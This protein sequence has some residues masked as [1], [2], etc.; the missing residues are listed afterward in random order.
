MLR[1]FGL[2][3]LIFI[4]AACS[5]S[6]EVTFV[7]TPSFETQ[8]TEWML[9][10]EEQISDPVM[11]EKHYSEPEVLEQAL[12]EV[13]L[14]H[15]L[16]DN[17]GN[18]T[19]EFPS[20]RA[21]DAGIKVTQSYGYVPNIAYELP[22]GTM[23]TRKAMENVL[24]DFFSQMGI[25]VEMPDIEIAPATLSFKGCDPKVSECTQYG[26][27]QINF[28]TI[29]FTELAG[30]G[31]G[32]WFEELDEGINGGSTDNAST[33]WESPSNPSGECISIDFTGAGLSTP[34]GGFKTLN[35]RAAKDNNADIDSTLTFYEAST[36]IQGP[37]AKADFPSDPANSWQTTSDL[38]VASITDY[39]D[40]QA[41]FCT[42]KAGGGGGINVA[43]TG[44]EFEIPD[45]AG[46][47]KHIIV[48][49]GD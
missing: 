34:G 25:E 7:I 3:T 40:L 9:E 19:G 45:V 21:I 4:L 27:P 43:I 12:G 33:A 31:D 15:W 47:R 5:S 1:K 11:L 37:V 24:L 35:M 39:D 30:D 22:D 48:T 28:S 46:A 18:S 36:I 29:S 38:I 49:E 2:L 20:Q 17:S 6:N 14:Y 23:T 42:T 44:I 16:I 8:I 32:D 41:R 10:I 13:E 26:Q